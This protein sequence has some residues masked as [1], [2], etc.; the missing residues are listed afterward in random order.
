MSRTELDYLIYSTANKIWETLK[1]NMN[2][3][4]S[5]S[6]HPKGR[7]HIVLLDTLTWG[8][9]LWTENTCLLLPTKTKLS[10]RM[11]TE[12][13]EHFCF[14]DILNSFF[15]LKTF[16][17]QNQSKTRQFD[18]ALRKVSDCTNNNEQM[19]KICFKFLPQ[20]FLKNSKKI[21]Y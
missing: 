1:C 8:F 13:T 20:L 3:M 21:P 18:N 7:I 4:E 6:I 11:W 5:V 19:L 12:W 10:N 2:R 15:I 17:I 14:Q 9:K 16:Q